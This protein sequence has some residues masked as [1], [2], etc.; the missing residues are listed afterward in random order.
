VRQYLVAHRDPRAVVTDEQAQYFGTPLEK[1]SLIPGENA[2]LG[3]R[4]FADWLSRT[5]P[6]R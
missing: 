3:S 5:G 1:R 2:L 6:Q 4:H